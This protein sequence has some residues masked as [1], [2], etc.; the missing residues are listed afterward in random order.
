MNFIDN[1]NKDTIKRLV[2]EL[3]MI[4]RQM[5]RYEQKKI[6]NSELLEKNDLTYIKFWDFVSNNVLNWKDPMK[7]LP[8]EACYVL[9]AN[10]DDKSVEQF[11]FE[12]TWLGASNVFVKCLEGC[13][14]IKNRYS[15]ILWQYL[16][17]FPEELL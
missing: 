6:L 14:I 5:G 13:D 9:I 17:K 11:Q 16:P 8:K 12:Y 1:N 4:N 2:N 7:E 15:N 10:L 3:I